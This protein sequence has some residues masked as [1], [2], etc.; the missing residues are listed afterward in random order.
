[1]IRNDAPRDNLGLTRYCR[2]GEPVAR[3]ARPLPGLVNPPRTAA[4]RGRAWFPR[5]A[6]SCDNDMMRVTARF[7]VGLVLTLVLTPAFAEA[8]RWVLYVHPEK[9]MS[10]RFPDKPTE[11]DQETPSP[12]GVIKFKV[13]MVS[14]NEHAYVAT[15]VVYPVTGKFDVKAALDGARDQALANIKGKVV[16]EKPIKLDGMEGREVRFEATGATAQPAIRGTVRIFASAKPPSAYMASAMKMNDKPDP[17]SQKFL[18]SVH[19]GKKV[20]SKP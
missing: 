14:D 15:A 8:P 13:A 9:L 12:I 2:S 17:N 4:T 5:L 6:K 11:T 16:A 10:V 1:V 18:D 3:T 19:L 7:F 20:E